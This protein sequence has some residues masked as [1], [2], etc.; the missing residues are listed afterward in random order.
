M[1]SLF[2]KVKKE[3]EHPAFQVGEQV[4]KWFSELTIK[5][6]NYLNSWQHRVGFRLRNVLILSILLLLFSWF[7]W[8]LRNVFN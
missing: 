8:Q 2:K 4:G 1:L 3:E 7:I 6:A 5:I